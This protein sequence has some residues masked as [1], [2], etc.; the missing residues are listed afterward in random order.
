MRF[1]LKRSRENAGRRGGRTFAVHSRIAGGFSHRHEEPVT[2]LSSRLDVTGMVGVIAQ[3]LANLPNSA[4]KS[5]IEVNEGVSRPQLLLQLL[6]RDQC[7]CVGQ[8]LNQYPEGLL[9]QLNA[10]TVLAQFSVPLRKFKRSEAKD[11]MHP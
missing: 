2:S 10:N 9:L 3:R 1:G 4:I 7:A 5:Y 6:P 8:Q 11:N